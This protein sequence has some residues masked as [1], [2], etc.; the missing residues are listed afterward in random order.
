M[1]NL[2]RSLS[3]IIVGLVIVALPLTALAWWFGPWI[4]FQYALRTLSVD[5]SGLPRLGASTDSGFSVNTFSDEVTS[6]TIEELYY[7]ACRR[8]E[9]LRESVPRR[10][11]LW[12]DSMGYPR[13]SSVMQFSQGHMAV[14]AYNNNDNDMV[15]IRVGPGPF[16][17]IVHPQGQFLDPKELPDDRL[18]VGVLRQ[19]TAR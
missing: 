11:F 17:L 9:G 6:L 16:P 4:R 19:Q 8:L 2:R 14:T 18:P 12:S 3:V 10:T 1:K 7:A 13:V 15:S 5:T